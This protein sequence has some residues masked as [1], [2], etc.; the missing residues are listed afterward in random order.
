MPNFPLT[1]DGSALAGH[2]D[3][4]A[5]ELIPAG[6]AAMVLT[7]LATALVITALRRREAER[8]PVL[9]DEEHALRRALRV[10]A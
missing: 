2:I 10:D 9:S 1:S 6:V 8:E 4:T 3:V 5:L 7:A